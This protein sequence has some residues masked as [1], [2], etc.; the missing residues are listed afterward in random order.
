MDPDF[1]AGLTGAG[2]YPGS[3]ARLDGWRLSFNK[4]GEGEGGDQV[5]A[6]LV[7]DEG[8]RTLGVVYRLPREHVAKLDAFEA[9]PEHYRREMLWVEPLTRRARQAALIYV[10]Q[11]AWIVEPRAPAESYL[12]RLLRGAA[13]HRLPTSYL[14][15][16][17]ALARGEAE[18]CYRGV[19]SGSD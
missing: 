2:L 8:C 9:V 19:D 15:W 7:E 1:L 16:L 13:I 11:P 6:N 3:P 5:T 14:D 17:Q 18:D 10:A 12:E 4:G